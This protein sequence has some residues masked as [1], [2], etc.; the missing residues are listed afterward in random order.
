MAPICLTDDAIRSQVAGREL[1]IWGSGH[2]G[3]A[4]AAAMTRME[5]P[6][7]GFLDKKTSTGEFLGYRVQRPE[8][9]LNRGR[10]NTFLI[11]ASFLYAEEMATACQSHGFRHGD[12]YLS[13]EDLKPYHF[14]IDVAGQCNLKC[15]TCPRGN[16]PGGP[17]PGMMPLDAFK[18]VIDKLLQDVPMLS[19]VQLYSWGEPLLNA[20]LPDMIAYCHSKGLAS[21][22]SSN[23]SLRRGLEAAIKAKPTWFR[24][25]LSG[26][27]PQTY[28]VVHQGGD[29]DLVISNL[30]KLAELQAVYA[31]SMF[32]EVN[33]HLYKHNL[34]G[35]PVIAALCQELGFTLRTNYAFIDPIELLMDYAAGKEL[36]S[37][38]KDTLP[39]LLLDIDT[40]LSLSMREGSDNCVSQNCFVIHSDLS[41]RRCIHLY[42]TSGNI[43]AD[44]FLEIPFSEI[45]ERAKN[46]TICKICRSLCVHRYHF[47]YLDKGVEAAA[48][49]FSH[50]S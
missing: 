14:E 7:A 37:D 20:A 2:F 19:D 11:L 28:S 27:D 50:I 49:D 12:D 41:F 6:I 8:V 46:C 40:A 10:N 42:Q 33:Y 3:A 44:N 23:L 13:H 36:P 25:S 29:F 47:P 34:A 22:V 17:P 32:V 31:P 9:V 45:L 16:T 30:R 48:L 1:Y 5:I 21:A 35:V 39:Y 38:V 4:I 18:Q 24:V 43:L 15:R 26:G